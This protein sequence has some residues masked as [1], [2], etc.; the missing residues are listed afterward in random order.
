MSYT[1]PMHDMEQQQ[2]HHYHPEP[3]PQP[4]NNHTMLP[5]PGNFDP[6]YLPENHGQLPYM[7]TQYNGIPT[8]AGAFSVPV[9]HDHLPRHIAFKRSTSSG[10]VPMV[11]NNGHLVHGGQPVQV[12]PA[13]WL[14]ERSIN[15]EFLWNRAHGVPYMQG[16]QVAPV[17]RNSAGF[18][19]PPGPH[20]YHPQPLPVQSMPP[21]QAQNMDVY[22]QI[23][24]ASHR[25]STSAIT[26]NSFQNG[27]VLGPRFVGPS[28]PTGLRLYEIH[29]RE[30]M[31]EATSRHPPHLR[32]I[33][34]DVEELL[35]LSERMGHFD[36]SLSDNFIADH[37]KTKTFV[38]STPQTEDQKPSNE[39][40]SFCVICQMDFEDQEKIGM[41]DCHHEYHVDCIKK[42]LNVK[43]N[44]PICKSKAL[45]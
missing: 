13:P 15:G 11:H 14:N 30:M 35:A 29:R 6:R 38:S 36:S 9:N 20:I 2:V 22:S 27:V 41:L 31:S 39:V 4:Y 32:P 8:P 10:A 21:V 17:N 40:P 34:V 5:P 12:G 44:C 37:L 45:A 16:Y 33:P 18:I 43:N 28:A 3:Y 1:G 23:A 19:H 42:W 25:H 24:S 26:A 7:I